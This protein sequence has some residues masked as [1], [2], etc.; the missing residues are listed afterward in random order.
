MKA[1]EEPKL[2]LVIDGR[3][4]IAAFAHDRHGA[5]DQWKDAVAK[6]SGERPDSGPD[7]V[8][9]IYMSADKMQF[10][11]SRKRGTMADY[12]KSVPVLA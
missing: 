3:G 8:T 11:I 9:H 1:V 4:D 10:S 7:V 6:A 2:Y 12:R 5:V